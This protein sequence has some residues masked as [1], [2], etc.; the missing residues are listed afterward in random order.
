MNIAIACFNNCLLPSCDYIFHFHQ[1]SNLTEF[2]S[3]TKCE[4]ILCVLQ[5]EDF[6]NAENMTMLENVKVASIYL[7]SD[8]LLV[9][10]PPTKLRGVFP[11]IQS[12]VT[13]LISDV[14]I[15][16]DTLPISILPLSDTNAQK[17]LKFFST[18]STRFM[19][20]QLLGDV[21]L[22]FQ[23]SI[24]A[25]REM[26]SLC[27]KYYERNEQEQKKIDEFERDYTSDKA[28]FWY[29]KDSFVY[30]LL[31]AALR[32]DDIDL[33]FKFRF[34]I[35]D[36]FLQ[37]NDLYHSSKKTDTDII[38][39]YRGQR[40]SSYEL[41]RLK[42][43][44]H[45][46]VSM[47]TFISTSNDTFLAFVF[48][49]EGLE[50]PLLESVVFE[51]KINPSILN[52]KDGEPF[53]R[54][55]VSAIKSEN[56][57]LISMGAVFRI[58]SIDDNLFDGICYI[59]LTMCCK[60]N[61]LLDYY[62][63][64]LNHAGDSETGSGLLA[65]GGFLSEMADYK[66]AEH[67][68]RMLLDELPF[69]HH[70]VCFVHNNLGYLHATQGQPEMAIECYQRALSLLEDHVPSD[71]R[72]FTPILNNLGS[73]YWELNRIDQALANYE[74][75][76]DIY[77]TSHNVKSSNPRMTATLYNNIGTIY[78]QREDFVRAT[79]KFIAATTLENVLPSN[80][81][82]LATSYNNL[83]EILKEGG[84]FEQALQF[85][86]RALHILRSSLLPNHPDIATTL[87]N[88]GSIYLHMDDRVK[89][90][91]Y[92]EEALAIQ[93]QSKAKDV[94]LASTFNNIGFVC[95][96]NGDASSALSH[97]HTALA[98]YR[99][100]LPLQHPFIAT[101]LSNVGD[102]LRMMGRYAEA[103]ENLEQALTI[104]CIPNHIRGMT[105]SSTASLYRALQQP[106]KALEYYL[107]ALELLNENLASQHPD[108][109]R[110]CTNLSTI[111]SDLGDEDHA[112]DYG[113]RAHDILSATLPSNHYD[114]AVSHNNLAM[115]FAQNGQFRLAVVHNRQAVR[116]SW[117]Q[118]HFKLF[119][120]CQ[121]NRLRILDEFS[122]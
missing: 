37:L 64:E 107:L 21:L 59:Q 110:V 34:F 9:P 88:I 29:T 79:T 57:L 86:K 80:H 49:G 104:E 75:A 61:E 115:I 43:N 98:I 93:M 30:R 74:R 102:A 71:H 26:V 81:P 109:A 31:N 120:I 5:Q 24:N 56:E 84:Q 77:L 20:F 48:S 112:L 40:V 96:A 39:V 3:S 55:Q 32:T 17:S 97:Y 111:Y 113:K 23:P 33:L 12:L 78:L 7:L 50:R 82:T 121:L 60:P 1:I 72:Y 42:N 65:L 108:V 122:L 38:T 99:R 89:A 103:L 101:A 105:Y 54:L 117:V 116:I 19:W 11:D 10:A 15:L 4:I 90:L 91:T 92:Y 114:L 16:I 58:E 118:N 95:M 70:D 94:D 62:R 66:R 106:A 52:D 69:D 18:E 14:T 87:N 47:N 45:G 68:Y 35:R 25:K 53:A 46:L 100:S 63:A 22:H 51:I 73:A 8:C 76:L 27:R 13:K 41:Q 44:V 83:A 2:L 85:H 6:D 67:Y 119:V 36:L 28:A